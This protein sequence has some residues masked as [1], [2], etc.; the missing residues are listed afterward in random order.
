MSRQLQ[1][2]AALPPCIVELEDMRGP[3]F[4]SPRTIKNFENLGYFEIIASGIHI[5]NSTATLSSFL[6]Q[7]HATHL[8]LSLIT[9]YAL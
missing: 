1:T 2:L 5:K 9:F 8:T 7:L 6:V 3:K 4:L